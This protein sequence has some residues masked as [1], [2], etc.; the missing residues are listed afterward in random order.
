MDQLTNEGKRA[1][2]GDTRTPQARQDIAK[3]EEQIVALRLR[4]TP[5]SAIGRQLGIT[6][7]SAQTAFNKSLRRTIT[8]DI[9]THHRT[10]L[11]ELELEQSEVW[12]ILDREENRKNDRTRLACLDRLNRVYIRRARLLGLDA[13]QKLDLR[14]LYDSG[15]DEASAESTE[16][17]RIWHA[18]PVEEQIRIYEALTN[19]KA[20]RGRSN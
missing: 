4:H 12:K 2:G 3:R 5:Y 15:V 14:G 18:L 19:A 11:A 13:P 9:K 1:A 17:Q 10:E 6:R 7:Q 16:N 20:A 8:Q